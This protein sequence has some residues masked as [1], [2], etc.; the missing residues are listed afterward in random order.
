MLRFT[1]V[2][3]DIK[4]YQFIESMIRYCI[5]TIYKGYSKPN[6]KFLKSHD[7]SKPSTYIMHLDANNLY[8]HSM[9]QLLQLEILDWLDPKNLNLDN[10]P[11][12]SPVGC[13]FEVDLDYLDEL[14]DL[15]NDYP[16]AAEKI[17]ALKEILFEYPLQI[18]EK[19]EFFIGKKRKTYS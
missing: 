2:S 11:D 14:Y 4:K 7:P 18:I 10:Y 17:K 5:S 16:V 15:H 3:S 1:V 6:N 19:N 13:L 8:E 9:M 12:D